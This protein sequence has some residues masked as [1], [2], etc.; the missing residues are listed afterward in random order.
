MEQKL[1][2]PTFAKFEATT[3]MSSDA[4]GEGMHYFVRVLVADDEAV[5]VRIYQ[6]MAYTCRPPVLQACHKKDLDAPLVAMAADY[7]D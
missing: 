3:F 5:H 4:E 7:N 1:S 2:T 6:P